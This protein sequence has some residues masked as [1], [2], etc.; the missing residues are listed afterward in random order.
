MRWRSLGAAA[1]LVLMLAGCT[2]TPKVVAGDPVVSP[3]AVGPAAGEASTPALAQQKKAAGIAACPASDASAPAAAKGLPDLVLPCLGGGRGVRLAGLRG[4][5]LV[6][7][8]WAQWCTPCRAEA[9]YLSAVA[10]DAG[11]QV[12]I[13]GIDY[14][15]PQPD[16]AIEFAAAAGWTY[17][18]LYDPDKRTTDGLRIA[19][20]P[21]QTV[22]VA[23]D[24]TISYVHVGPFTSEAQLRTAIDDHLGV[25]L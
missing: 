3:S 21:P 20:S 7:N 15:D 17:P 16:A 2:E 18:Q 19:S 5:P 12:M 23:A 1:L 11:D 9:P 6:I 13:M 14:S 8:V 10:K 22:F 4:T 25:T 24:G